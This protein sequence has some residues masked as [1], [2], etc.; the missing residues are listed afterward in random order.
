MHGETLKY[1]HTFRSS[2]DMGNKGSLIL[3]AL[4]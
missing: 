1:S 4:P 2:E 3:I